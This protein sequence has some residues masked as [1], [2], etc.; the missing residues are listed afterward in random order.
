MEIRFASI[1]TGVEIRF[2]SIVTYLSILLNMIDALESHGG[3]SG[4]I[5]YSGVWMLVVNGDSK[6]SR[7]SEAIL[8]V[9]RRFGFKNCRRYQ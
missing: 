2:M 3:R 6:P 7:T 8:N 1:V 4:Q 9:K 5:P